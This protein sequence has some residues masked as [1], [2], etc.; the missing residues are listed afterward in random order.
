LEEWINRSR[1]EERAAQV[2]N[3]WRDGKAQPAQH[4][5]YAGVIGP[6]ES[7]RNTV[8]WNALMADALSWLERRWS[9][10]IGNSRWIAEN[11]LYQI[12]RRKLKGLEVIQHAR[13][14]WIEPQHLDVYVPEAGVAVEYMGQQHF[15]PL[16]FFGGQVAF[17]LLVE[18]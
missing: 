17:E 6:P 5:F 18:R 7:P 2:A 1:G 8:E 11:Q 16:E 12:L 4:P 15:E 9:A 13:P 14:T 3:I 10:E